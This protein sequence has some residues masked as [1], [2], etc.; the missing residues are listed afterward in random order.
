MKSREIL[1]EIVRDWFTLLEDRLRPDEYAMVQKA[2]SAIYAMENQYQEE[3]E[4]FVTTIIKRDEEIRKH[5]SR[6]QDLEKEIKEY[7]VLAKDNVPELVK[8]LKNRKG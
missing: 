7:K 3:K 5:I 4:E 2:I 6:A 8:M 1:P